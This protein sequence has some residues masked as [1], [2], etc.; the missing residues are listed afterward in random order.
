MLSY[1][2]ASA[3]K[4]MPLNIRVD[5]I[6]WKT[7]PVTF[8]D[9]PFYMLRCNLDDLRL[10]EEVLD[11]NCYKAMEKSDCHLI[12]NLSAPTDNVKALRQGDTSTYRNYIPELDKQEMRKMRKGLSANYRYRVSRYYMDNGQRKQIFSNWIYVTYP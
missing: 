3:G 4:H 7:L 2:E 6:S 9:K 12:N 10:Q 5:F 8:K 11:G 1:E